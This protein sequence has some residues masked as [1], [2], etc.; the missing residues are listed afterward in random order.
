[1]DEKKKLCTSCK[2]ILPS[3][4][5]YCP[6]CGGPAIERE[7]LSHTPPYEPPPEDE[8]LLLLER[9][10]G[11]LGGRKAIIIGV[12]ALVIIVIGAIA[13]IS[14]T[15]SQNSQPVAIPS[16]TPDTIS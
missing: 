13:F 14:Y 12:V 9:L 10:S 15:H 3:G 4:F 11:A 5:E 8:N 2:L 1:M 6:M 16:G 7:S